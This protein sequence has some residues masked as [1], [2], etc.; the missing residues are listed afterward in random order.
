MSQGKQDP[1]QQFL[2][3]LIP[4]FESSRTEFV[5]ALG[6][7]DLELGRSHLDSWLDRGEGY[8]GFLNQIAEAFPGHVSELQRA[9]A[10]TVEMKVAEG[11]PAW[12]E[13]CKSEDAS[14]VPFIHVVG[15]TR[16][17]RG[18]TIF[19]ITGGFERWNTIHVPDKIVRLSLEEQL[20]ALPDLMRAFLREYGGACPFFG[21]VTGFVYVRYRDYYRF[22]ADCQRVEHVQERFRRG[23]V[24][25]FLR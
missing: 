20:R 1:I 7:A 8:D 3:R 12:L 22:D 18:I 4:P 9:I 11:D 10:E 16:V 2:R 6:Y 23:Q 17:P 5:Q 25:L 24:R 15:E 13:R 19:G 21:V 14:F